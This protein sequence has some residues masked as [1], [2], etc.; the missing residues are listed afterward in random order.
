MQTQP[1]TAQGRCTLEKI[2]AAAAGLVHKNGVHGTSVDK[3][4]AASKAGKSQFYHYFKSKD[5]VIEAI[6]EHHTKNYM[7]PMLA[8]LDSVSSID[9]LQQWSE[10][11]ITTSPCLNSK[12]ILGCPLAMLADELATISEHNQIALSAKLGEMKVAYFG[13]LT[14]IQNSGEIK[15]GLDLDALAD[16]MVSI[17]QG[18]LLLAKIHQSVAPMRNATVQWISYL[19]V[20]K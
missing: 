14:R 8:S 5:A 18:G 2:V 1:K 12:P 20:L 13:V 19:R 6:I 10:T 15:S 17:I 9:G 11:V 16:G 7:L 3:I 4:I